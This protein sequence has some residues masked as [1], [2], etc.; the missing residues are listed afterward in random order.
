M[1]KISYKYLVIMLKKTLKIHPLII[2]ILSSFW[3]NLS[4]NM[5][6]WFQYTF[7]YSIVP[8]VTILIAW[9]SYEKFEK[10]FLKLKNRFAVV[11]SKNSKL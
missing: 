9:L 10:P 8:L 3:L 6:I 5:P 4:V 7:I 11:D 2:F 1:I